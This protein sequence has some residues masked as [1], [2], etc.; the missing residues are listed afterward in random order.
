M[1][2]SSSSSPK[3]EQASGRS[4]GTENPPLSGRKPRAVRAAS[5]RKRIALRAALW[6]GGLLLAAFAFLRA[7]PRLLPYAGQ[8]ALDG[9]RFSQ[10]IL[11]AEGGEI[12]VLPLDEG[13]RRVFLPLDSAPDLL[14]RLVVAAE[15]KR[16]W[17][18]PGF[19]PLALAR[20]ALQNARAGSTVSGAS[21][22]SMQVARLLVPRPRRLSSKAAEAWEAMQLESRIGKRRV[23]EL[24]LSLIPFGR[25]AEGFEAGAR[26][27]FGAPL[28]DMGPGELAA[29]AVIPRAPERYGPGRGG[30]AESASGADGREAAAASL[31]ERCGFEPA[32]SSSMARAALERAASAPAGEAWP[33]RCPHFVE[34]LK[35]EEDFLRWDARRPYRTRI[36]P[37]LQSYAEALLASMVD[38]ARPKRISNAACLLARPA[39][40]G[41]ELL[42]AAWVG[43]IDFFDEE[44]SGQ[45]DGV[46]MRR[47]P[48]STLKPF[49]YA[50]ALERGFTAATVIPDVPT[51]FGGAE[52]YVPANFNNQ[53]NGPVRLRQALASSLNVPAVR[54]LERIGVAPFTELLIANGF[55]SLE[56]QRGSLGLGLALGN[57]EV[58]LLELVRGY[59]LFLAEGERAE[60]LARE[61]APV[62]RD[63]TGSG[64]R[65]IQRRAALIVRDILIRR[66][67][68]VLAFGR[69]VNARM[70]FE[71]AIKTGTSDQFNNIWAVGFTPDLIGGVWMGNFSG[72][73]VV[74]TADSGYPARIITGLL[75]AFSAHEP[76]P[77]IVGLERREIC[78][79]SGMAA[80]DACPHRVLE[81]FA[82]GTEPGPCDWHARAAD[83]TASVRYPQE[84]ASWLARYRYRGPALSSSAELAI[85]KPLDGAVFYVDP[86]KSD[87]EQSIPVEATGTGSGS[88]RLDGELVARGRFP[89]RTRVRPSRGAHILTIEEDGGAGRTDS[90]LFELR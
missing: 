2:S 81:W 40:G 52:V 58:S 64:E 27:Y 24:Y 74:G 54:T 38:E 5:A 72:S 70:R 46:T 15:D 11:D 29:L 8:E 16:F 49:L 6:T 1:A 59:G 17:L 78:P 12:Q 14:P 31:L 69:G 76:F 41:K 39:E 35:G 44:A 57:A 90:A 18:H 75:E 37:A 65:I 80:S 22:I 84:Y 86:G 77:P 19:D 88:L 68:R 62:P 36:E 10:A 48:G 50:M 7:L 34:W 43:S 56:D 45:V 3:P 20:A 55:R 89:I 23:L 51:D 71:G 53:F 21:T 32:A 9:L 82:R 25:N 4:A 47:Q 85:T 73:T 28:V 33:F 61:G 87:E 83:G 63:R 79:L 42:I 30:D 26:A 60:I 66:P 67:D 13:L